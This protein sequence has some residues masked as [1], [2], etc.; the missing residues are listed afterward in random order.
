MWKRT[1]LFSLLLVAGLVLAQPLKESISLPVKVVGRLLEEKPRLLP[2]E[3]LSISRDFSYLDLSK[4]L[5]EPPRFIEEANIEPPKE[6]QG[7]G[8][9]KDRVLY[10][11]GLRYYLKGK[12]DRAESK[13]LD[14]LSLQSSA[15]RPQAEYVLGLIYARTNRMEEALRFF[16]DSCSGVHPFREASCEAYYA[17]SFALTGKPPE[18]ESPDL[19]KKVYIAKVEGRFETPRCDQTV[20]TDYCSYFTDFVEGRVKEEYKESTEL[21]RAILLIQRGSLR[22]AKEILLRHST[23]LSRYREVALYYLGVIALK[24][25]NR[26]EAYKLAS[27]LEISKPEYSRSLYVALSSEDVAFSNIA[28]RLTGSKEVL[29]NSGIL[30]YNAGRYGIAY[31]QFLKA[32]DYLLAAWSAFREGDYWRAYESLR[33]V[34][35]K[36]REH[37]LWL[38]ESLYWLGEEEETLKTLSEIKEKY[39]D[40]YR[41]YMGWLMFRKGKWMEA[42]EHFESPYHRALALYNAGRYAEVIKA[43]K[44]MDG[45]RER[46]LKAKAAVSMGKGS[47]AREFLTGKTDEE[48][49]LMGVSYFIEGDYRKALKYFEELL[50][51][52]TFKTKALL[53]MA[54]SYYN[55]DNYDKAKELYREILT[56]YPDSEEAADAT[57]ALAQIELQKPSPEL[58]TL[59]KEFERKFPGSPLIP[60]LKYQLANLYLK[61]GNDEKGR[62]LLEELLGVEHLKGKVLIK[63]AQIEEDPKRKEELLKEAIRVGGREDKDKA[64]GMLLNLYLQTKEFEKLA[65]FLSRGDFDDRKRALDIYIDENLQ[66][67]IDLFDELIKENPGDEELREKALRMYE[68]TKDKKYLLIAKESSDRKVKVKALYML[69]RVEKKGDGRKALEYFVEA[70]MTGEGVQPY[71]NRSIIEAANILVSLKAKRDASCLLEKLDRRFLTERELREVK[72]LKSELP[73]CEVKK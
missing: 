5:L 66:K 7:C 56:L 14:L 15:F 16:K 55:L 48:T 25:G 45:L 3:K 34:K 47:L 53:K 71:Y 12:Y 22:E 29:R 11:A 18:T 21:R 44:G 59:I 26:E 64:T 6:G 36:E 13:L 52:G 30:S 31:A 1:G 2:P 73:K 23:P 42:Y 10:R 57:L 17:L 54:D 50:K 24:E 20:F 65:D 37:Y 4:D 63:L 8:E 68:K 49:Y 51:K 9:P 62:K 72:I 40:L 61:E 27:L 39:P 43:L 60:D 35:G 28:Y 32:G 58:K 69:G 41:E 67:A 38:L 19:W 33:K 70:V 46:L